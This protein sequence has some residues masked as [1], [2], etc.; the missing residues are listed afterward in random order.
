M[1]RLFDF[2]MSLFL[3]IIS[4]IPMLI[5]ALLVNLTSKGPVLYWSDRIGKNNIVFKMPKFRTM[6]IDTM[7]VATH[8]LSNPDQH[9]TPIGKFLRKSS[10][11]ELPQLISIFKG[12]MSFVGPRPALFNQDDLIEL[13]TKKGVYKL[14]PGLTGWAQINGRDDIPVPVKVDFDEYYMKHRSFFFDIKILW[15][16]IFKVAGSAGIKH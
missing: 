5:I 2:T 15:L 3:L 4:S 9:L 1:K 12:D 14:I 11:D 6:N 10:M 7:A 16:T 8:L 13:R